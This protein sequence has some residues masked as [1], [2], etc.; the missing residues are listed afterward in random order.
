MNVILKRAGGDTEIFRNL[1]EAKAA[2][3]NYDAQGIEF[4]IDVYSSDGQ[5]GPVK[6]HRYTDD[7]KVWVC[8]DN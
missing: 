1:E 4:K 2:G 5:P 7:P 6:T 3:E 8:S